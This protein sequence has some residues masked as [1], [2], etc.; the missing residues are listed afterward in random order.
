M[1]ELSF[2]DGAGGDSGPT[3][4]GPVGLPRFTITYSNQGNQRIEL[5]VENYTVP[6]R[7]FEDEVGILYVA[8]NPIIDERIAPEQIWKA[9]TRD[10]LSAE[11][12]KRVNGEFLLVHLAKESGILRVSSD[13]FTSI[14]LFYVANGSHF[15]GSVFYRDV[16]SH[17]QQSGNLKINE[18]AIFEFLWLQGVMGT[19]TYDRS[20]SFLPAASTVTYGYRDV[21]TDQYWAPSFQ[22]K[23]S[24][25][26][27]SADQLVG[28]FRQSLRRKTS[29]DPGRV[30]LMLSG[31][32]DSWT[33]LGS[34]DKPPTCFTVGVADNN[35][36]R[37]A[38][39]AAAIVG[40]PHT[41]IQLEEDPYSRNLDNMTLIG[42]GMHAFDHGI[43]YG[44]K[45][46]LS[47][48][49]DVVF[50]GQFIDFWFQGSGLLTR[51][52]RLFGRRMSFKSFEP[53]SDDLTGDYLS[54]ISY[55]L[56]GINLL[57]YVVANRRKE[58]MD[59]LRDSVD[60]I[61]KLGEGF[62]RTPD[63]EWE[64]LQ[65]HSLSRRYS[66]SNLTS[67]GTS[68]EQRTV[69]FD[70][71][72]F[73]LYLSLPKSHRLDAK[74]GRETL[75]RVNPRLAAIPTANTNQ[76]P[77]HG[78]LRR[79]FNKLVNIVRKRATLGRV[80]DLI[81]TPEERTYPDRGRMFTSQPKLREIAM[82]M[83]GSEVL[84][85]L[86][87]LNMNRL[88]S[89]VPRWLDHPDKNAGSFMSFLVTVDRFLKLQ[90]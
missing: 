38:R 14:P 9:A 21:T 67:I 84:S 56:K 54:R 10:G 5:A 41:F 11:F 20:S 58:L 55:R 30:G 63:D 29:D 50:H 23:Q 62:C 19:K 33:V 68:V 42:G 64:Y 35:E 59:G 46:R 83:S 2:D 47:S 7:S 39:I 4:S 82:A 69:V 40:A 24:S 13:R 45:G 87:F 49:A 27:E 53:I 65:F 6:V 89:D 44:L 17:L 36:V 75:V 43:Y 32:T 66:Y 18:S 73:D 81:I 25:V 22:K 90:A 16:W 72:I 15:F 52:R 12:L 51:N 77:D 80:R 76:R 88:A 48:D 71:D 61:R 8:G 1:K 78:P 3:N 37:V 31:G 26:R 79:D 34:F 60:E 85:S 28:L 70:N 57:D 74:L 86:G